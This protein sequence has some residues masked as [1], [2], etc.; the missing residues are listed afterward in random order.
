[1]DIKTLKNILIYLYIFK[2]III[3]ICIYKA[4][5]T[6]LRVLGFSEYIYIYI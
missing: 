5:K 3:Y 4:F 1:M 2:T 6:I